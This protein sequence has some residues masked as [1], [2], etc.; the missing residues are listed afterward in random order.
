MILL[1]LILFCLRFSFIVFWNNICKE[2]HVCVI[3]CV[4]VCVAVNCF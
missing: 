1:I 4:Y 2:V 3:L